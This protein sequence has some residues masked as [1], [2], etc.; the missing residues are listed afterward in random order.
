LRRRM[1]TGTGMLLC[2][3]ALPALSAAQQEVGKD[4]PPGH[5][6]YQAVQDLA[7]K[8]LIKGY[9]PDADF[10]GKRTLT[11]YEMATILQRVVARMDDLVS[12]SASKED[13]DKLASSQ[14][15][16]RELVDSF[17]TEMTVIGTDMQ[18]VK[19]DLAS[20]QAQVSDLD[21][22]VGSLSQKVDDTSLK[23]DQAQQNVEKLQQS[24]Q[25][26]L[27]KKVDVATGHLRIGGVFQI[28]YGTAF[29][30][31]MGGNSPTNF[32][33]VP[34]GRNFG[35][36]VGDTFRLRRGEIDFRGDIVT[37]VDY[38]AMIDVAKT[39]TGS[40]A[41]LQDLWVGYRLAPHWRL[42]VGAQKTGLT[43]E[44]TR[45]PADLLTVARA[46]MNEDL[47]AT[48]G[49]IGNVRDTGAALRYRSGVGSLMLGI[50]NDN[51]ATQ[52]SVDTDRQKFFDYNVYYTGIRH[53]MLG[54]WGGMNVDNISPAISDTRSRLG[55]TLILQG[56]PHFFEVEY[57][58]ADD[59]VKANRT[60]ADGGYA[61]YAYALTKRW[62]IVGRF[63]E[64]D[65]AIHG[66]ATNT[67]PAVSIPPTDHNLKEYTFGINYYI[68]GSFAK[69][70]LNYI[71]DDVG[72]NG[73]GF[74][75]RSRGILLTN[76]QTAF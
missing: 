33:A 2:L 36:G 59:A 46:V 69:I 37:N 65:P 57:G 40:S 52:N 8:G 16:I 9:P 12:H 32:S 66:G 54:V 74:F 75:G 18:T 68:R 27:E 4:V 35:G 23:A 30:S 41:P 21:S 34:P 49:R 31:S 70:Q 10:L 15:E 28:W 63:D 67:N 61:L 72:K 48:A 58:Y 56:G 6:A 47:P 55:G 5:W 62:Q 71:K 43:E 24:T 7:S 20:L 14:A 29:G 17:K 38:R 64:W 51:G 22:R 45:S 19:K 50:W 3:L 73:V 1:G 42:E 76:F 53:V 26:A 44:G 39:G 60:L 11:R 25:A 13:L